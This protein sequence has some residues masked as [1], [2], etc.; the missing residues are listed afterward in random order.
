M[1]P[2]ALPSG[3]TSATVP[4]WTSTAYD[5]TIQKECTLITYTTVFTDWVPILDIS[6]RFAVWS[7]PAPDAEG[8]W[9]YDLR[10]DT[11]DDGIPNYCDPDRPYPDPA[12]CRITE[13]GK[14]PAIS[15]DLMVYQTF[16]FRNPWNIGVI[17]LDVDDNGILDCRQE[18]YVPS[19]GCQLT[20]NGPWENKANM[21]PDIWD[22]LVVWEHWDNDTYDETACNIHA[23]DLSID[24]DGTPNWKDPDRTWP[25]P[26]QCEI[27]LDDGGHTSPAISN[28][29]VVWV[30]WRNN[31]PGGSGLDIFGYDLSEDS[32]GD[33]TPNCRDDDRPNPDSAEFRL[34]TDPN[35]QRDP[36][37][38]GQYVVWTDA[39]KASLDI[40]G[41]D[42]SVD[43]D[44]DGIPNYRETVSERPCPDPAE[45]RITT[46]LADQDSPDISDDRVVWRDNRNNNRDIYGAWLLTAPSPAPRALWVWHQDAVTS[47]AARAA[48]FSFAQSR[49]IARIY[50]NAEELLQ[51]EPAGLLREFIATAA[52]KG[53]AVELLAGAPEWALTPYH[54][55]ALD[56]VGDAISFTVG[57]TDTAKPVGVHLDAE[58]HAL[59]EWKIDPQAVTPQYLDL[60]KKVRDVVQAVRDLGGPC[61]QFAVDIPFWYDDISA[62]FDGVTKPLNQHVQDLADSVTLMAY[63]DCAVGPDCIIEHVAN[64]LAYAE[65]V[66]KTIVIGVETNCGQDPEK[67]TFC[68]EGEEVMEQELGLTEAFYRSSPA[69]DG[70]AIHYY[71]SY[72]DM[73]WRSAEEKASDW[74]KG[75]MVEFNS[76]DDI[77]GY[78][79]DECW[80]DKVTRYK[81][82]KR[83]CYTP[84]PGIALV[85]FDFC[86][87]GTPDQKA[88]LGRYGRSFVYDQAVGAIALTMQGEM[89][90]A[91]KVLSFTSSYQNQNNPHAPDGSFGFSFQNVGCTGE[92]DSFYDM[93]YLRSGAN[94]WLGHSA[95]FHYQLTG[96]TRSVASPSV[97]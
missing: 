81:D 24:G 65:S 95:V 15:G 43:S 4:G 73:V 44:D 77:P 40:Y 30:D 93:D 1:S 21:F 42:L 91:A 3:E 53:M 92:R 31:V 76:Y 83:A 23:Y 17:D 5:F 72:R 64:E 74:L 27:T 22:S 26:A 58:P 14:A 75:Q 68:E 54:D 57:I 7:H 41:Y 80:P 67:I 11:D 60:L 32:D 6:D 70:F 66:S 38:S 20:D 25:D 37:I 86:D 51:G 8:I 56:F 45:F 52:E 12:A 89:V 33:G 10:A 79:Q 34:T 35:D 18:G 55:D 78:S 36:A 59:S 96:V 61:L 62:T 94:A 16:A 63:R 87:Y 46:N 97:E 48:F 49:N 50:L 69:F 29:I 71:R 84:M 90:T 82:G 39:R 19:P 2:T 28:T 88:Y 47:E 9:G 85:S 13:M